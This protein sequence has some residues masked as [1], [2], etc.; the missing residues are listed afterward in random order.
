SPPSSDAAQPSKP[1]PELAGRDRCVLLA[2]DDPVVR[3]STT[4]L[5]ERS[6]FRVLSAGDGRE[7]LA[8][9]EDAEILPD[10]L[11]SDVIMPEM[12]GPELASAIR[13][14]IPGVGIVFTSGYVDDAL[15]RTQLAELDAEFVAKP[16]R[17]EELVEAIDKV[18][19]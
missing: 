18:S 8:M 1:D 11:V 16:F 3:S 13:Q 2:E 15:N 9:V 7:A 19:A 4:R 12:S 14:R 6:G 10:V 5:L 17:P